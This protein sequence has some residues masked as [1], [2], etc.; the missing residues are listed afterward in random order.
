MAQHPGSA[1]RPPG[2]RA[3][4]QRPF[5]GIALGRLAPVPAWRGSSA[6]QLQPTGRAAEQPAIPE[7][8]PVPKSELSESGL[9]EQPELFTAG[10]IADRAA[11][12]TGALNA[13]ERTAVRWQCLQWWRL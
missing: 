3:A 8:P 6:L 13:Q 4:P 2:H 11:D 9:P 1:S 10:A 7:Q 12:H 5:P